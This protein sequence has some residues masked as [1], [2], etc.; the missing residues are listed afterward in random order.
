M[1][2]LHQ[3]T[4]SLLQHESDRQ[5]IHVYEVTVLISVNCC[6]NQAKLLQ[7]RIKGN[8]THQISYIMVKCWQE[9]EQKVNMGKSIAEGLLIVIEAF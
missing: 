5:N 1:D 2:F 4:L 7:I 9:H 3:Q 6:R 8:Y